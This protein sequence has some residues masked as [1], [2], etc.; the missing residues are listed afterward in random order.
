MHLVETSLK[1]LKESP[2]GR[3]ARSP[4]CLIWCA[5][6]TLCGWYAWGGHP[7]HDELEA[8]LDVATSYAKLADRFD[9]V[10]DTRE[11]SL[12]GPRSLATLIGWVLHHR[13][14]LKRRVR[15]QAS[16]IRHDPIGLV[17]AGILPALGDAHPLRVFTDPAEAFREL[18]GDFGL[19]ACAEIERIVLATRSLPQELQLVRT[20]LAEDCS[21]AITDVAK[22]IGLVHEVVAPG[23]LDAAIAQAITEV[24]A[25][26]PG[27][28]R[29]IKRLLNTWP[30]RPLDEYRADA[31]ETAA[32]V[33][34][35]DEG[36]Q[37]LAAFVDAARARATARDAGG[38]EGK[39][40]E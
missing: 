25:A 15:L 9:V 32:R 20:L 1:E 18:A 17:F 5:S 26:W 27:A 3:C 6:P 30:H 33:R 21:L 35:S 7:E 12:I 40:A 39:R 14:E 23:E 16:V 38:S 37:G 28:Q 36:R 10:L 29:E 34:F 2:V 22:S 11:I 4:S 13:A 31:I 19:E 24:C 8:I